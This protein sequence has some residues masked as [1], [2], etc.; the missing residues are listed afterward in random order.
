MWLMFLCT[1]NKLIVWNV[2]K[3]NRSGIFT[4]FVTMFYRVV[5]KLMWMNNLS[6]VGMPI[7]AYASICRYFG[8]HFYKSLMQLVQVCDLEHHI[9]NIYKLIVI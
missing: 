7:Q 2:V 6:K 1:C 4:F 9:Q 3:P 8:S 5:M